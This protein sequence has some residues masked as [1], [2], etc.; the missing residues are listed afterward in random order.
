MPAL[1]PDRRRRPPPHPRRDRRRR[2]ARRASGSAPSATCP[3]ATASAARRCA[4]RSTSLES[5]GRGATRAGS[6]GRHVRRRAQGRA[7]P[8]EPRR[9]AVVP[10]PAGL[11]ERR[12]RALDDDGRG[13]RRDGRRAR[14]PGRARSSSRSCASGSPTA[15]RSPTSARAS[16]P[17]ASPGCSTTRSAAR[18]TRCSSRSTACVPGE[19]EERIEV[20]S[21]SA[22]AARVL[23]RAAVRAGRLHRARR[24]STPTGARSS[25]RTT[26]S[27]PTA[28]ASS[29]A[30][31]RT[32]A[33]PASSQAR[34]RSSNPLAEDRACMAA[35]RIGRDVQTH[36]RWD[37]GARAGAARAAGRQRDGRDRRLRGRP[38]HPRLVAADVA[39]ARLRPDLP[40]RR[41][42]LRRGRRA[43]ATRS[44]SRSSTSSCPSG[45]G[46]ASSR[47]SACCRPASSASRR[48]ASSTSRTATRTELVPRR[49]HPDRAVLRHD[50]RAGGRA[51]AACPCP[52]PHAG[53][54]NIDN[55]HL[56]RG[57]HALPAGRRAAARCSR[58]A[59]RTRRRATARSR[60]PASSAR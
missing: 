43:R 1:G 38:D 9:A 33:R 23:G 59:T 37:V 56:T 50:G 53:G 39:A 40:A 21:A 52:P 47:A 55:R 20:V 26:C 48:S 35:H 44:R 27:A 58:S 11:R 28:C 13:R 22:T 16:P 45:A 57:R 18:S 6:L 24:R 5:V 3:S 49:P 60:S 41:A 7:R 12:A 29:S 2:A 32:A 19:A 30:P 36:R 46:P 4:R 31:A 51:C 42:R 15:S 10:A 17:R 34:S 8:H 25:C 14:D 54:G